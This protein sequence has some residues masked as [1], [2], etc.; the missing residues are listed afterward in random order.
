MDGKKSEMDSTLQM[1]A[2]IE[3]KLNEIGVGIITVTSVL[4]GEATFTV[5]FHPDP[6]QGYTAQ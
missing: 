3:E 4:R 2:R 1:L 6:P 5:S